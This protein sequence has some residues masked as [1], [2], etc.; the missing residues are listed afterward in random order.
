MSRTR[1]HIALVGLRCAGKTTVARELAAISELDV[2]D[3]DDEL[4]RA[5]NE[6]VEKER[7]QKAGDVLAAWGEATFR[8]LERDVLRA[9]LDRTQPCALATGGGVVLASE[10]RARLAA[11]ARCVYLEAEPAELAR[12]LRAD[13]TPRPSLTGADPAEELAQ[14]ARERGPLYREIADLTLAAGARSPAELAREIATWRAKSPPNR[15][16]S[17]R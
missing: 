12:R 11:Y 16:Q 5:A 10:N 3:L 13:P 1:I 9:A 6:I 14:L 2:V 15:P 8:T 7:F 4:V 17:P